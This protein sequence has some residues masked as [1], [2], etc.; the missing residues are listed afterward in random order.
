MA[1]APPSAER[2]HDYFDVDN[3][4]G[5][6]HRVVMQTRV[7]L[8]NMG[9]MAAAGGCAEQEQL[10]VDD[11][12]DDD[13]D[14]NDGRD[15]K[16]GA[17]VSVPLWVAAPLLR[18][19]NARVTIPKFFNRIFLDKIRSHP[20]AVNLTQQATPYYYEF[21][22]S[23]AGALANE[24]D[25]ATLRTAAVGV[26]VS[27]MSEVMRSADVAGHDSEEIQLKLPELEKGLFARA[28]REKH[29]KRAWGS[30]AQTR[31]SPYPNS[32]SNP[33]PHYLR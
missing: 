16:L 7:S 26:F 5:D 30:H 10:A 25:A 23:L 13:D 2:E 31:Y 28:R 19:E 24:E 4:L 29:S 18:T 1:D 27:R 20:F 9:W 3:I 17:V 8:Y 6:E 11:S 14:E 22:S 21:A 32:D 33:L 15:L 12:E